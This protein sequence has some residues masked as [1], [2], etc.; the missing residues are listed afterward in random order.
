MIDV[1]GARELQAVV[2]GL[3]VMDREVAKDIRQATVGTIGP[4]WRNE[5]T[6]RAHTTLDRVVLTGSAA[7][8]GGNPPRAV[9]GAS[10]RRMKGG[11]RP[12]DLAMPVEFGVRNR[13]RYRTY[14]GRSPKGT[15]YRVHRRTTKQLPARNASGRVV[16][17][18][19]AEVGPRLVSLWV[20]LV[21][22]KVYDAI[23][24]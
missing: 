22:R 19:L 10:A 24:D 15:P 7:V 12:Q 8:R 20:Q 11:G 3:K 4:V 9:A 1:R 18:A 6:S 2:L 21:V 5:V 23:E 14:T 13:D 17:P 16:F